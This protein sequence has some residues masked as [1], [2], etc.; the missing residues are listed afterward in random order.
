MKEKNIYQMM[1]T[2]RTDFRKYERAALTEEE[3]KRMEERLRKSLREETRTRKGFRGWKL[4][5]AAAA[6][7]AVLAAGAFAANPVAA[8]DLVS[9]AF[10][11]LLDSVKGE[12]NEK[13]S[14]VLYEQTAKNVSPAEGT[15]YD[16]GITVSVSDVYCDGYEL[17]YIL[18]LK[19]DGGEF[20]DADWVK[21]ADAAEEPGNG[22]W[23]LNGQSLGIGTTG[24]FVKGEDGVW[25]GLITQDLEQERMNGAEI[26]R[27]G[28]LTVGFSAGM[29]SGIL[30]TEPEA[31]VERN[32]EYTNPHTAD[33]RGDWSL[34][35]EAP[36]RSEN[37][38]VTAVNETSGGITLQE[39]IRTGTRLLVRMETPEAADNPEIQVCGADGELLSPDG[40]TR[41]EENGTVQIF[42]R[43]LYS[44][45][46]S[47]TVRA[48]DKNGGGE[49]L[50]EFTVDMGE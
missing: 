44:E 18:N 1:N 11:A 20:K 14:T 9:G 6:A 5:G 8:G 19:E 41:L 13:E 46:R 33:I 50:A 39:V 29:L 28:T 49:I 30:D 10:A 24:T 37:N 22:E 23:T 7:C 40:G 31:F 32:G 17:S 35:F 21:L 26:P 36:I 38:R 2:V 27:E 15:A 3:K 25:S 34:T 16:S 48:V 42:E 45:S 47:L 4:A 43:F 12:K